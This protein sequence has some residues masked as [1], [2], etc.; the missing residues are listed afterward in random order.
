MKIGDN[1][2]NL[3]TDRLLLRAWKTADADLLYEYAKD[4]RIGN[5]CG[6]PAH[7]SVEESQN[8]IKNVLMCDEN[9]AV[10]LKE[11]NK[12][13]GNVSLKL[14]DN[15][16]FIESD[17]EAEIGYWVACPFW[18]RGIIPEATSE[19]IRHAFEDLKIKTL[20]CGYYDGNNNS[21]RA[22]EKCGFKFHHI[23]RDAAVKLLNTTRDEYV[24]NLTYDMWKENNRKTC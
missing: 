22:M 2:M 20:W 11:E 10:E 16:S 12:F 19:L 15:A 14:G 3:E 1:F 17:D 8:I 7:K 21:K 24:S 13:V 4:E 23:I 5:W 6:F 9:Y 18:G